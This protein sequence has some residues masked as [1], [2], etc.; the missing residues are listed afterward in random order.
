MEE[1]GR[2][3]KT[4]VS[5]APTR[6]FVTAFPAEAR[7]MERRFNRPSWQREMSPEAQEALATTSQ[8]KVGASTLPTEPFLMLTQ[9]DVH[10]GLIVAAFLGGLLASMWIFSRQ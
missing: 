2:K 10:Y 4:D 9:Q 6:P 8:N 7:E 3:V 5:Y 1:E